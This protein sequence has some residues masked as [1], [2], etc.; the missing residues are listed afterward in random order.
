M[1]NDF[2]LSRTQKRLVIGGTYI[3]LLVLIVGGNFYFK[4]RPTCQDNIKNGK[5]EGVDCGTL[6][7]GKACASPVQAL[8]VQDAQLVK[9]PAGDY[10][11]AF[12]AYN[13]NVSY[14]VVSATYNFV[15]RNESLNLESKTI[16]STFYMLPGQT[17]F[18]VLTS[19]KGLPDNSSAYVEIKNVVWEKV[20]TPQDVSFVITRE[21]LT[22]E[23][24][25][26][27]YQAV[28]TN[29]TNFDLDT[30]DVDVVALDNS[31]TVIATNKTNFQT[32]L[33]KTDRSV[34]VVWP[35]VL[36]AD[37]RIQTEVNTNVFNNSNFLKRNGTQEKFQQYF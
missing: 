29:N 35:F 30:I 32:F 22:P 33:S 8:M 36:P 10:D 12:K 21:A 26:T 7:C 18:V 4:N 28:I 13:P 15:A 9:T 31:G 34:K 5:E 6:A 17:R 24:N 16:S 27:T 14:G 2:M 11:L 37:T 20:I 19:I 25:Q 23:L 1:Y 3:L